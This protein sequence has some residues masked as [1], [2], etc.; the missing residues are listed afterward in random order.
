[1]PQNISKYE[2]SSFTKQKELIYNILQNYK[3]LLAPKGV[4][5]YTFLSFYANLKLRVSLRLVIKFVKILI[6]FDFQLFLL[7]FIIYTTSIIFCILS[8]KKTSLRK[9]R[10]LYLGV[11]ELFQFYFSTSFF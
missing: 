11:K 8:I 1:M 9:V 2:K 7:Q 6:H 3:Q 4:Q 10:F 5:M